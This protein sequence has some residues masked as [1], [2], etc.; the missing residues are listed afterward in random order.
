MHLITQ[1][2]LLLELIWNTALAGHDED[3]ELFYEK[4]DGESEIKPSLFWLRPL[5]NVLTIQKQLPEQVYNQGALKDFAKLKGI[6][7]RQS[8]FLNKVT[9]LGH[10]SCSA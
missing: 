6:H 10:N 3:D 5:L 1:I 7:Q 2:F 4:V 9:G 8:L